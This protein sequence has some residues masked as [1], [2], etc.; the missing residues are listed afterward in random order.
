MN[1]SIKVCVGNKGRVEDI[2]GK[3]SVWYLMKGKFEFRLK[4][5]QEK[6]TEETNEHNQRRS[7]VCKY[8]RG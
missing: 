6:K 5:E 4:I 8:W 2:I 7:L 3:L 1:N